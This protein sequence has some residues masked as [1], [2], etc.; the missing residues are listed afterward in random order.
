MIDILDYKANLEIID[1]TRNNL[2]KIDVNSGKCRYNYKCHMNAVHEAIEN[3]EDNIAMVMYLHKNDDESL[4]PII[5]FV[6]VD[7]NG[8]Y[9]DNTLGNWSRYYEY[10]FIKNIEYLDYPIINSILAKYKKEYR[11]KLSFFTKLF[12]TVVC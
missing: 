8:I 7:S 2:K 9:T 10:Y 5:H 1:Y 11:N 3:N 6:N 12:S 4:E